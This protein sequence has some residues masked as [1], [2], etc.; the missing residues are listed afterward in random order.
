MSEKNYNVGSVYN[1]LHSVDQIITADD[2]NFIWR[3]K[4]LWNVSIFR[5]ESSLK[6]HSYN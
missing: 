5:V 1:F 2:Y 6:L 3:K 4:V